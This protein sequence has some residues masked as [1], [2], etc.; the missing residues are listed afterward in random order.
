MAWPQQVPLVDRVCMAIM[1]HS[2]KLLALPQDLSMCGRTSRC[3]SYQAWFGRSRYDW[4]DSGARELA[5]HAH[6][7]VRD[8]ASGRTCMTGLASVALRDAADLA[9]LQVHYSLPTP[10]LLEQRHSTCNN[11]AHL[12]ATTMHHN[13]FARWRTRAVP[14]MT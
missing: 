10:V 5:G 12:L 3:V 8:A 13:M 1:C 2:P 7:V 14:F 6:E 11:C 4:P 9:A